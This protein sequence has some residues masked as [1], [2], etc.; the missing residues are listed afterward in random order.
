[1]FLFAIPVGV[2]V[3]REVARTRRWTHLAVGVA[4][5]TLVL[6]LIP[7]WSARVT[8]TAMVM[9]LAAYTTDYLPFDLPGTRMN[10]TPPKRAL[11][12][13]ME[14]VRS[15]LRDIKRD[16]VSDGAMRTLTDRLGLVF[17]DMF[18]GTRL[19]FVLAFAVAI[20]LAIVGRNAAVLFSMGSS[21]L[22]V[23]G[24]LTQAHTA[25]WSVYYLET[26]PAFAFAAAVGSLELWRRRPAFI[27]RNRRAIFAVLAFV[28]IFN[29]AADVATAR[30]MLAKIATPIERFRS[31]VAAL[32]TQPNIVF[33]R[34]ARPDQRNMHLSLVA[35]DGVL[36]SAPTWVVH[37]RGA[38]NVRLMASAPERTPYVYDEASNTF[39]EMRR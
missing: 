3:I 6:G 4:C 11:P 13:E 29:V 33:V 20:A 8:G 35:N 19:P 22:L 21:L 15:F 39:I 27:E 7:L 5:G 9:P 14:R 16:Q 18:R 26:Y 37:D 36:T 28:A 23:V 32:T 24:Y 30:T 10:E 38:D 31:G 1:M 2:V 17:R 25:D 34:Y 12:A